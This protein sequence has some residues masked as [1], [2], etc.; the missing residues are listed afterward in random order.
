M[1]TDIAP[2]VR[3]VEVGCKVHEL[4]RGSIIRMNGGRLWTILSHQP[5]G[6]THTDIT[7][8]ELAPDLVPSNALHTAHHELPNDRVVRLVVKM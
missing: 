6:D 1:S 3:A 8:L 2:G 5:T 4:L 7:A